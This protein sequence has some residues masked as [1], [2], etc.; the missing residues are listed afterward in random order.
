[1]NLKITT[2][3][4]GIA[5][6]I[7]LSLGSTVATAGGGAKTITLMQMSDLH[8][9]MVPHQEVFEGERLQNYSGGLTKMATA[10]KQVRADDPDALLL[11][12]DDTT[13]GSAET[14][15]TIS[16]SVMNGLNTLGIDVFTPSN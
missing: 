13:H 1:M 11:M 12:L 14:L 15:F 9:K 6:G 2:L 3:T 8:G 5:I 4:K 16:D 7:A 10:I